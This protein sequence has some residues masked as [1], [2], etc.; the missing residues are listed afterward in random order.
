MALAGP[1][2]DAAAGAV[3]G[4]AVDAK[5]THWHGPTAALFLSVFAVGGGMVLLGLHPRLQA[6]WDGA[7]RPDAK[8]VFDAGLGGV[9]QALHGL[10][11]GLHDGR[12]ARALAVA[13]V[14]IVA[15]GTA[16]FLTGGHSPGTRA[17]LPVTPAA[18]AGWVLACAATV[19]LVGL[20]R[21]RLMALVMVAVVGLVVAAAFAHLSAPDLALTQIA[22]EVVT[23]ILMLLALVFLPKRTPAE[24]AAAGRWAGMAIAA[25]AGTGVALLA[26]A[27]MTRDPAFD[28][29]SAW[30]MA[31]AKPGGGGTNA[32]NVII[33][34]FRGFDTYGEII[35]L[36][37]AALVI[38][39]LTEALL[40]P[41]PANDRLLAWRADMPEAG[42]R[43][44]L[45]L[46]VAARLILPVAIVVGIYMFLRGH[47]QPGGGFVA[48]LIVAIALLVQYMASGFGW[49]QARLRVDYH[50]LIGAGMV[51]AGLTGLGAWANGL[52]FLTSA[53]GYVAFWPIEEFEWTTA[54]LFDLGVFLTVLGAVMLAL[55]S[56]SRIA[57]RAG[58]TVNLRPFEIDP[59]QPAGPP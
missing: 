19:A 46:A 8:A 50:A 12:L 14:A 20:H 58:E 1:L 25:A 30:H 39:A 24:P 5:I 32:V 47:N 43:H 4:Q 53:Y 7:R 36:G 29:I 59:S 23:V 17:M 54:A 34:D 57:V 48:G 18:L 42:D 2:V 27:L 55:A 45:I 49:T 51:V 26:F 16:A 52:P 35:V 10:T 11:D 3:A 33:V 28:P 37:I 13:V 22:V 41:G 56:L 44:P 21:D 31:N 40:K 9:V 38:F 6:W 15:M